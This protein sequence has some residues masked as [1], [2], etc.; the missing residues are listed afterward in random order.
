MLAFALEM[1]GLDAH[2][3]RKPLK[4]ARAVAVARWQS[5]G[6]VVQNQFHDCPAGPRRSSCVFV[7]SSSRRLPG[8]RTK[9]TK[10]ASP[11]L[12][13]AHPAR[14]LDRQLR[15][16]A[17]SR[18]CDPEPVGRL[19]YRQ[20]RLRS[21][22]LL[23]FDSMLILSANRPHDFAIAPNLHCRKALAALDAHG[24]ID[25]RASLCA[26]L[27]WRPTGQ[28]SCTPRHP[29]QASRDG[30]SSEAARHTP[31]RHRLS[32]DVFLITHAGSS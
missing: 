5:Q 11:N 13:Y 2:A 17:Q 25:S 21:W 10:P 28:P 7:L 8:T 29:T 16:I 24:L 22:W 6:M 18:K 30:K 3:V 4:L 23:P 9:A 19:H 1:P 15:M 31:A 27:Q 20:A 26:S 32:V 14:P 12:D